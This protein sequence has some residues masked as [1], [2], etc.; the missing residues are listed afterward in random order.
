M[1]AGQ[2]GIAAEKLKHTHWFRCKFMTTSLKWPLCA[3][4]HVY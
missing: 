1:A 2:L 4:Q 3:A